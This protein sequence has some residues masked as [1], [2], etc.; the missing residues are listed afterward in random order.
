MQIAAG[1]ADMTMTEQPLDGVQIDP[2]FEQVRGKAVAQHVNAA[3]LGDACAVARTLVGALG[4][5]DAQ[6]RGAGVIAKQPFAWFVGACV[7]TQDG[8][9]RGAEQGVTI[10]AALCVRQTYVVVAVGRQSESTL[11][12][13]GRQHN[14]LSDQSS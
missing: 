4:G 5:Q 9:Q 14:F 11:P 13:R 8:E 12:P 10:L 6:G 7:A 3:A 1:G 2:A